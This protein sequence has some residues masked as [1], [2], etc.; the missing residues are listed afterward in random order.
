MFEY[1]DIKSFLS[2]KLLTSISWFCDELL[3]IFTILYVIF[4]V[5][6]ALRI[7]FKIE[8]NKQHLE[9]YLNGRSIF[10][11]Y[12]FAIILGAL[13]PFCVC[14]T[15]GLFAGGVFRNIGMDVFIVFLIATTL[16]NNIV[17]ALLFSSLGF[18]VASLYLLI[19]MLIAFVGGVLFMKL[20]YKTNNRLIFSGENQLAILNSHCNCHCHD[21]NE[22]L[23]FISLM[24]MSNSHTLMIIRSFA[25]YIIIGLFL[26]LLIQ[27]FVNQEI[28]AEYMKTNNMLIV[29]LSALSGFVL[30][31][32]HFGIIPLVEVITNNGI[33]IG[34]TFV[35]IMS[36]LSFS[37]PEL[38]ILKKILTTKH[39]VVYVTYLFI[40]FNLVGL[41]LN[42]FI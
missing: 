38:V 15:L 4:F 29:P 7:Y 39:I 17:I 31:A 21:K 22:K 18:A 3:E 9:R 14:S 33:Q 41:F 30:C 10:V 24:K 42:N 2:P 12:I 34:I 25:L 40:A 28:I 35:L 13:N 8:L 20:T 1:F 37:I 6:S 11:K 5:I 36:A 26:A 27:I 23:N 19:A 32:S 16:I